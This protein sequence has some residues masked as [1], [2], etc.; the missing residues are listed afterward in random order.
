MFMLMVT[1]STVKLGVKLLGRGDNLHSFLVQ[2][3]V[4]W[5]SHKSNTTHVKLCDLGTLDDLFQQWGPQH[6]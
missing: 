1:C 4:D 6:D 2:Q 5:I 3:L